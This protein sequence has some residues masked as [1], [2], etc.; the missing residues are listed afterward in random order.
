MPTNLGQLQLSEPSDRLLPIYLNFLRIFIDGFECITGEVGCPVLC[1][2]DQNHVGLQTAEPLKQNSSLP[3]K[4]PRAYLCSIA[5]SGPFSRPQ[6]IL[7][8]D[9]SPTPFPALFQPW[10]C[11]TAICSQ[12]LTSIANSPL[13][14]IFITACLLLRV[15]TMPRRLL[16]SL[17]LSANPPKTKVVLKLPSLRNSMREFTALWPHT[18]PA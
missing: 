8:V 12:T 1:F 18:V 2:F 16:S 9:L 6:P 13:L 3:G 17:T 15:A 14:V 11:S 10:P 5:Q 7:Q 4:S